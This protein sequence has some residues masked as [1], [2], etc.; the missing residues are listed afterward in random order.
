MMRLN[1]VTDADQTLEYRMF[2]GDRAVLLPAL[3]MCHA[4]TRY[5]ASLYRKHGFFNRTKGMYCEAKDF[6]QWIKKEKGYKVLKDCFTHE[7]KQLEK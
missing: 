3:D 7:L 2:A 4:M 1:Q 6:A 5:A